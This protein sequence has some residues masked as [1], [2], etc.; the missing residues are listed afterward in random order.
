MRNEFKIYKDFD[1]SFTV[2][3]KI[4]QVYNYNEAKNVDL[5]YDRSNFY[6]RPFWTPT[7][8]INDYAAINSN[9]GNFNVYRSASFVRLSSIAFAYTLPANMT[10]KMKF[11]SIKAYINVTNAFVISPWKYFDP[12][13]KGTDPVN[14]PANASPVPLTINFGLNVV[15]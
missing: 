5:F 8:P 4:G 12:E 9:A 10:N 11:Q 3:S 13:Y 7:N 15:L 1:L 2:N 14:N 6:Q